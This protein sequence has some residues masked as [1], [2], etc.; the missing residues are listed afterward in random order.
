M[1]KLK[2]ISVQCL[3]EMV[4]VGYVSHACPLLIKQT[5]IV[6]TKRMQKPIS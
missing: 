6:S 2:T 4:E 1:V 5:E 3:L